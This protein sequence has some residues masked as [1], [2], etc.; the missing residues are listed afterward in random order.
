MRL[1]VP[2]ETKVRTFGVMGSEPGTGVTHLSIL[3][4]NYLSVRRHKTILAEAGMR[5]TFYA[6]AEQY[7]ENPKDSFFFQMHGVTYV[8]HTEAK[9]LAELCNQ[10][11]TAVVV[12]FGTAYEDFYES[13]LYM[14]TKIIV[15]NLSDWH[16]NSL[17]QFMQKVLPEK[18]WKYYTVFGGGKAEKRFEKEF[19]IKVERIP[20][21]PDPYCIKREQFDF[22]K[23]LSGE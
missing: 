7:F 12:D 22:F 8:S 11:Y 23:K 9:Q 17:I 21:M 18:Q 16:R 13:F 15:G 10:D 3:L 5:D 20:Y 2:A 19:H 1:K 4:A 6:L 14:D